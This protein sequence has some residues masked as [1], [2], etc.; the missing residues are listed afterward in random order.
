LCQKKEA[1]RAGSP[2]RLC[3]YNSFL[4]KNKKNVKPFLKIFS[5][6]FSQEFGGFRPYF[7]KKHE[8]YAQPAIEAIFHAFYISIGLEKILKKSLGKILKKKFL[9]GIVAV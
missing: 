7:M 5:D 3:C 9:G 6:F 2:Q 4:S 1:P 8:K